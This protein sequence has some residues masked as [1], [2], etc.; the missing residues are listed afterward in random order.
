ML[1]RRFVVLVERKERE[2]GRR[3]SSRELGA[4]E[5]DFMRWEEPAPPPKRFRRIRSGAAFVPPK[6]GG[7]T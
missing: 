1:F 7:S 2:L 4:L 5:N 3:L 6:G